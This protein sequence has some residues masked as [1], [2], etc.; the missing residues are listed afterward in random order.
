M[1]PEVG[2]IWMSVNGKSKYRVSKHMP[3][4]YWTEKETW[5]FDVWYNE[6]WQEP[7]SLPEDE[8]Y[9]NKHYQFVE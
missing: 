1:K 4:G 7:D 5:L 3:A 9:I 8:E 6:R 2:Q